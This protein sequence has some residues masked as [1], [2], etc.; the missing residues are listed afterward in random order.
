MVIR[1]FFGLSALLMCI[2]LTAQAQDYPTKG[3]Q[4]IVPNGPGGGTDTFGRVIAQRLSERLN[5]KVIVDW[6]T[7]TLAAPLG[8][9]TSIVPVIHLSSPFQGKTISLFPMPPSGKSF[10]MLAVNAT[11]SD[12]L[13]NLNEQNQW[14]VTDFST[15]PK[16]W[17]FLAPANQN[18]QIISFDGQLFWI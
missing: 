5:Q 10:Q 12:T 15:P 7:T 16:A 4:L 11:Y 2:S 3:I 1:R 6:T 9:G 13:N 14:A 18:T 8:Q 17:N